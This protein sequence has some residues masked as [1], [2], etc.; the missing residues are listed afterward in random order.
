MSN[1]GFA[2]VLKCLSMKARSDTVPLLIAE[3]RRFRVENLLEYH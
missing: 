2:L 3:I 1:K